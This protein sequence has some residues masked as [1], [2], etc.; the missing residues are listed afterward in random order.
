MTCHLTLYARS[1]SCLLCFFSRVK[2]EF[3]KATKPSTVNL[4]LQ[5]NQQQRQ[6]KSLLKPLPGLKIHSTKRETT[7][8][9]TV[10]AIKTQRSLLSNNNQVCLFLL[11]N[12]NS[13]AIGCKIILK[14]FLFFSVPSSNE[15]SS[16]MII[17]TVEIGEKLEPDSLGTSN[18]LLQLSPKQE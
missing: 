7:P 6:Q 18:S 13:A 15:Q 16:L 8:Q 11:P 4:K 12:V 10:S 14:V 1:V 3:T 17:D 9:I 5:M 2:T